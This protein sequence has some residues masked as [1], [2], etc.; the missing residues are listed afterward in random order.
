MDT[1]IKQ[2]TM[3]NLRF[4]VVAEAFKKRPLEVETPAE[5]HQSSLQSMCLTVRRCINIFL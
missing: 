5:R 4:Q 2:N 3:S 1:L